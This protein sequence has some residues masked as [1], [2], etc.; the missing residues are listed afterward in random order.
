MVRNL[1]QQTHST[2]EEDHNRLSQLFKLHEQIVI[3]EPVNIPVVFGKDPDQTVAFEVADPDRPDRTF[4]VK[5]LHSLLRAVDIPERL[6]DQILV[7]VVK[8]QP[9][10]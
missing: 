2:P 6:V 5:V 10:Q 7:Y 8:P 9:V 4:L 3:Y 1:Q